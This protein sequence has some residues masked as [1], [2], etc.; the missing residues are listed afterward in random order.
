M[1]LIAETIYTYYIIYI[2]VSV[3][4][5]IVVAVFKKGGWSCVIPCVLVRVCMLILFSSIVLTE[6]EVVHACQR[7]TCSIPAP[8]PEGSLFS[9]SARDVHCTTPLDRNCP[10]VL[11]GAPCVSCT[12]HLVLI[13][14]VGVSATPSSYC[15]NWQVSRMVQGQLMDVIARDSDLKTLAASAFRWGPLPTLYCCRRCHL[16]TLQ[17]TFH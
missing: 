15:C 6:P 11:V 17:C 5:Y 14:T 3:Y 7:N 1:Y 10:A 2:I 16:I 8:A 4:I 9:A 13:R 12:A